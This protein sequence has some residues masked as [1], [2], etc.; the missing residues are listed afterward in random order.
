MSLGI[1]VFVILNVLNIP[2]HLAGDFLLQTNIQAQQKSNSDIHCS[3]HAASY[4]A[5]FLFPLVVLLGWGGALAAA[6]IAIAHY[7]IDRYSLAR[8]VPMLRHDAAVPYWVEKVADAA[9]H[10]NCNMAVFLVAAWAIA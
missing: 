5:V 7:A 3:A 2:L 8:L 9:L 4:G 1:E 10:I 6:V